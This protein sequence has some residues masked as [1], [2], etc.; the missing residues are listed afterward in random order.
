MPDTVSLVY[1]ENRAYMR[2]RRAVN[3]LTALLVLIAAAPILLVAA[4]CILVEDGRP[5]LFAQPRVGRFERTF[6]MFKLRTMKKECC[7]DAY[8]PA[9]S[10]DSRITRTGRW[11][12]KLSIDELP[13]LVNVIRGEMSLVGPRP[14]MPFIVGRYARWQHLRHLVQPG[15]TGLWQTSVRSN[16]PLARPE[17]TLLDLEYIKHVSPMTDAKLLAKTL[18]AV[19]SANGAV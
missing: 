19:V 2:C 5:I 4:I 6:V 13:Q 11:L 18:G 15:I 1:R 14:E 9:E 8:S 10:Q 16:V 12:R 3:A 7:M 17:A